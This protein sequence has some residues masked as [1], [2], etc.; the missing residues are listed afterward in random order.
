MINIALVNSF[1]VWQAKHPDMKMTRRQY[2]K[3]LA[4]KLCRPSAVRRLGIPRLSISL[5]SLIRNTSMSHL[6]RGQQH[7]KRKLRRGSGASSA[8]PESRDEPGSAAV[9]VGSPCVHP[10]TLS[11]APPVARVRNYYVFQFS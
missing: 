10:A 6:R 9:D 7:S 5:R 2:T 3:I 1:I 4:E 8:P 11:S